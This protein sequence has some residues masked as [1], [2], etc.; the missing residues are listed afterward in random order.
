MMHA[1]P[2]PKV[3]DVMQ[4]ELEPQVMDDPRE[5]DAY[6]AM[7]HTAPNEAFVDRLIALGAHGRVIDLGTGPGHVPL[8]ICDRIADAHITG[9]D[10]STRML[11]LAERR[12][13]A[14]RHTARLTW[15]LADVKQLPFEDASFDTVCS[16][17]I[18]HHIPEPS[19][20]L[21][22]AFRVL[23]PGGVLLIR[24]LYRP[25]TEKRLDE[26][27]ALHAA[28]DTP[29]QRRMFR[30]SLKAALT[31]AELRDLTQD[32]GIEGVEVVVDTDRHM[33]LQYHVSD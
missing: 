14:S 33:S 24:D 17:T 15:Q 27:V 10:L 12:G 1:R 32:L 28:N 16:N 29:E 8:M 6:D 20:L 23:R 7:D 21:T 2:P 19:A 30:D 25:D 26:L 4:R 18:L 9:V 3:N 31:P 5:A 11:E 22:E 13:R